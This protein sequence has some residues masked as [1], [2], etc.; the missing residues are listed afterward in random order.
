MAPGASRLQVI[1]MV[2]REGLVLV[3]L[4]LTTGVPLLRG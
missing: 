2:M 1:G 4:G 3:A